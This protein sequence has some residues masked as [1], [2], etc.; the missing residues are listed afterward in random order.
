M[1]NNLTDTLGKTCLLGLTYFNLQG[2]IIKQSLLG[3]KVVSTD[4]ELGITLALSGSAN[5]STKPAEFIIP[6]NLSCWFKAPA[7]EFHTSQDKVKITN[8]D[9]LVTWDIHQTQSNSTE[10]E[11]QWWEWVPRDVEPIVNT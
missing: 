1:L 7:G 11:Q 8:P 4:K 9:F 2:D 10:G 5:D 6:T 3:G